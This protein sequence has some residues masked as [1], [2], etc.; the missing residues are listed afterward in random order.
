MAGFLDPKDRVID[1]VL[2]DLGKQLLMTGELRFVYWRPFDDEVD[3]NPPC[4]PRTDQ[5]LA[6][7]RQELTESPLIREATMGYRGAS[8]AADDT[9]N[10]NRPMYSGP[11]GMGQTM[12]LPQLVVPQLTGG[13]AQVTVK[14]KKNSKVYIQKDASGKRVIQQ[15]GP[16]PAGYQRS[17]DDGASLDASYS[18][19]SYPAEFQPEGFLVRVFVSGALQLDELG[20]ARGGF[21]EVVHNNDS[22]GDVVYRNDVKLRM[23]S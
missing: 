21:Q 20:Q 22:G 6:Q 19:G 23:A 10:L 8:L 11:S 5:T 13:L 2:T 7:R 16:V 3:Y 4:T 1:M 18:T 12:A 15:V 17:G 9:T 14:Q